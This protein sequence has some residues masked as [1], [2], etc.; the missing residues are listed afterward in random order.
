MA[1][2]RDRKRIFV[3]LERGRA[4][5]PVVVAVCN[6]LL[7]LMSVTLLISC[8]MNCVTEGRSASIRAMRFYMLFI[9]LCLL[10]LVI[11]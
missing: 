7:Q 8:D 9:V 2:G 6:S 3:Y 10:I 5:R 1:P 11:A 4:R